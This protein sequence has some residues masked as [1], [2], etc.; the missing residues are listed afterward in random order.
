MNTFVKLAWRNLWRNRRRTLITVS[1][2][3]FSLAITIISIAINDG[4]HDKMIENTMKIFTG[5]VQVHKEGFQEDPDIEKSYEM[6]PDITGAIISCPWIKSYTP[7]LQFGGLAA[8]RSNS[9]GAFIIGVK[10]ELES[11]VTLF[12]NKIVKGKYL[13]ENAGMECVVGKQLAQNLG[14]KTGSPMVILTRG[15]DGSTGALKFKVRGIFRVTSPKMNRSTV[16]IH[17]DD[18]REL[19][20]AYGMV[21]SI[22]IMVD[23]PDQVNKTVQYLKSKLSEIPGNEKNNFEVLSWKEMM[24]EMV[25]F[26]NLDNLWGY[27]FMGLLMLVVIFGVLSAIFSSILER[28]TEFGIMLALG[29]KPVQVILLVM[30]EA[31]CLTS[32]GLVLGL[33]IGLG[34]SLW[35]VYN[36][37]NLPATT[38]S[39]MYKYGMENKIYF[40]IKPETITWAVVIIIITSLLFAYFPALWASKL[41]PDQAIRK[42]NR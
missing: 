36:P 35:G 12:D 7:R 33:I 39:V 25:K 40:A 16:L 31:F 41:K 29:T 1:A 30:L 37:I 20:R 27:F 14:L 42:I 13:S 15:I 5:F 34:Y 32:M 38:E 26:I 22:A 21:N 28:T 24:P 17:V 6:T 9:T 8:T 19:V 10:P 4:G 3:A 18:A 11:E 2:V 23:S